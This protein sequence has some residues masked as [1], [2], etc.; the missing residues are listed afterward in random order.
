MAAR[1]NLDWMNKEEYKDWLLP[2]QSDNTKARCKFC[3]RTFSLSN[4]GE[5][6]LKSHA[7]GKKHQSIIQRS[8]KNPSVKGFLE[9]KDV[10]EASTSEESGPSTLVMSSSAEQKSSFVTKFALTKEHHKAEI[11]WA[12]KSVMSQFS[13]NSARDI[14]DIFKAM[15]PDSS[16][17]QHMSCGPTKL[18]YL[19]SF[20]IAP[21]FRDLLLADLKQTSCFV[22]SFDESFNHELQK[23]QMDFT[24]R[25]FK[26]NKVESRCLT[27]LFLGHTTAKDLK[28]KF[29]EA[30]E[31][32][33]MKK[34]L[35]ISMDGPNVNWK[36]LDTIAEDRSSNEQYPILLNVGSCSLHVV[37]GAFRNGIKQTNWEIDLLL[38]S[39]HSLF[40]ETPARR[41]DYTK[42]T[43]SRVF[44]QQ[45]CGHRWLEDK[46]IAERAVEIWPNITVFITETLKKPKNQIPTSAS[47]ATVRSAVQSHLTI[48]KLQFFISTAAIMKPYLQVFQSDA[49]LLPFVTSE[50][51]ALLQIL[52][53]KFV[54]REELEAADSPYKI[55]KL[56]VSHAASHVTPSEIDIGFAAKAT[57]DKALREKRI[58]QLQVL[59][60]RKEC[61]VMLQ[62]TVSK[63]QEKSPIKYNLARKLVSM[64]PRLMVSNPDNAT[65]MFQ[66]VLQILI[67]NR[68]KT[69]EVADTVLAQYRKFVFNAKKYHP[70]KFS[71]FK[72]GEDRLDS[73]LSETLQAQEEY[74]ELWLT[75]Q[76][77]LTLSHGQ[78]TVER[79]F[80]VNKEV[81][82]PNL[83]ELS[84][85]A[86]RLVHSSVLA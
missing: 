39:L 2:E 17:A 46:K 61:E 73:F 49:P 52:M 8:E 65:K 62:T 84:L 55:A 45:F 83:Q 16:I 10:A 56:N 25:Y 5:P 40:N 66:Q 60:F 20:G 31:Q 41:E 12:L 24:V 42:I 1:F 35:Q 14:T 15:F 28:K 70:E 32:L 19:I 18:S 75:M 82:T 59:E 37:H 76:L 77:L 54:K 4:M 81:L 26:N 27:S 6:S 3:R 36:L 85:Q 38:R 68:W 80:S 67:E 79:G 57:V 71:S 69:P 50:L 29:E 58:R 9:K 33:D 13:Y 64:D 43:G 86:I 53:G 30:T 22:V 78:A 7:Q 34:L 23:E 21:Y 48:A 63:M 44:P 72:S 51:H 11:I 74:Q 47:F